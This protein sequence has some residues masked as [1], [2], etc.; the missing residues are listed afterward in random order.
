MSMRLILN[1]VLASFALL[2]LGTTL[3]TASELTS[4]SILSAHQSGASSDGI[5]AM[6][7]NLDNT[8]A[9]SA[10][11]IV[12]LRD[13]GV[14]ESV[15]SAIWTRIA[16]PAPATTPAPPDDT[17]LF[18][19]TRLIRSGA[20]EA[21]IAEQ[22]RQSGTVYNLSVNDMLYL[23]QVGAREST[24]TALLATNRGAPASSPG[25]A[26]APA[27]MVFD[28]LVFVKPTFLQKNREGRLVMRDNALAWI[29]RDDPKQ[30]FT[31]ET[32]G[33]QKVW[34]TCEAR[35]PENFCYQINFKIVQGDRYRFR[36]TRRAS[37]SNVAVTKL[38][39]ALRTYAPRTV[40]AAPED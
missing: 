23:K 8:I 3:T 15:I 22:V 11:D 7:N 38:M 40:F 39:D 32:N 37:G 16:S 26:V 18:E 12:T 27:E 30:N 14:P 28:N 31:F 25:H 17:R 24:I 9:M 5:I 34:F 13:G 20:T 10:G 33:L 21:A 35:S 2:A 19:V 36:D 1:V 29:D 4:N 6:V